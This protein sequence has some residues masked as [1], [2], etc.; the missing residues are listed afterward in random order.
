MITYPNAIDENGEVHNIGSITPEN[1][2][3]HKYYC[4]GCDKELVPVLSEKRVPHFRH[5][6]NDNCNPETYLHNLA[7]KYLAKQFETQEKF[8]VS[9]YVNIQ[10]PQNA[11]CPVFRR[12]QWGYCSNKSLKS[13]DLKK[14]YDTCQIEG[15]YNGFRADVLLTNSQNPD[16]PP[17][18]LEVSVSHDCTQEKIESG[19]PIIEIKVDDEKSIKH[20]IVENDGELVPPTKEP[21]NLRFPY[22]HTTDQT[23]ESPLIRF[24]N[25]ERNSFGVFFKKFD[26]FALMADGGIFW[27]ED[28]ISCGERET[29]HFVESILEIDL[30]N[31]NRQINNNFSLLAFG[32]AYA[33]LHNLPA[34]HCVFCLYYHRCRVPVEI[35]EL[36]PQTQQTE[37][38]KKMMYNNRIKGGQV[39]KVKLANVC[40]NWSLNRVMCIDIVNSFRNESYFIW[41]PPTKED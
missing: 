4:L 11:T 14:Q 36:N 40:Q 5:L 18:F 2:A 34:K 9:Y 25:F 22:I 38:V 6:A 27:R 12:Y 28:Y 10:C 30:L 13:V 26:R 15:T 24:Y 1:R 32:R 37:K 19:I 8:N 31:L 33:L 29:R 16:I 35:E 17:I 20:P 41:E 23:P 7:K 3:E 39:D 21:T